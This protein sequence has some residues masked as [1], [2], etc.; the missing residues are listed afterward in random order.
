MTHTEIISDFKKDY[1]VVLRLIKKLHEL[2][3][4]APAYGPE[5]IFRD[6]NPESLEI[7]VGM[8]EFYL[9]RLNQIGIRNQRTYQFSIHK[10]VYD[11]KNI[12]MEDTAIRRVVYDKQAVDYITLNESKTGELSVNNVSGDKEILDEIFTKLRYDISD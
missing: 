10:S 8:Y 7:R 5:L 2:I 6:S 3:V 4:N 9:I 11:A 1:T 12:T